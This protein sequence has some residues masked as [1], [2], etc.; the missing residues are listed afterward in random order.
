MLAPAIHA[1]V[2]AGMSAVSPVRDLD[3]RIW[4][5]VVVGAGPAGS[6]A[7]FELGRAGAGVLLVDRQAFPRWKVCGCSLRPGAQSVLHEAGLA[8]V[9]EEARPAL[10]H[11][12]RLSGWSSVADIPLGP[13]V[14]L[15]RRVLDT[16]LVR[17]AVSAGVSFLAPARA[18]LGP[19][20]AGYRKLFV[21]HGGQVTE[22]R[23]RVV[24][25]ADGVGSPL[26]A[27]AHGHGPEEGVADK[28]RIG[29]GGVFASATEGYATGV[30]HMAVG[31]GGY[32]GLVRLEDGT[33]DV[34]SALDPSGFTGGVRP[35]DVVRRVLAGAGF[36]ELTGVPVEGW[37]GT[38]RLTRR[39][40]T[41]GAERLLAVGDAA[42]YVEPFTGEGI[43]WALSG[44]RSLAPIALEGTREWRPELVRAWDRAYD[45]T[46]GAA[47]RFCRV[48][49]WTL[50]RSGLS[51]A[52]L[53][54]LAH[55]P[56]LA[57]PFVARE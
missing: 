43:G 23:A 31:P 49:S 22:V 56:E 35:E 24:I 13:S 57:A 26:L 8:H 38:P 14:A 32:V 21:E 51:R 45:E 54:A 18:R 30:I 34:A 4:D 7:A 12:L 37:R 52:G 19:C 47:A 6:L 50:R 2:E 53:V 20:A 15:S 9:L 33:L 28:S 17:A 11:T 3:D 55:V 1:F 36:R 29:F 44:A 41:R 10:L 27:E 40:R 48:V 5:A 39:V 42:G 25:A 46:I 16:S